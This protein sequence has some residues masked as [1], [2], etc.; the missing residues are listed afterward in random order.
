M[1]GGSLR[2]WQNVVALAKRTALSV[3]GLDGHVAARPPDLPLHLWTT[4][5]SE[6]LRDPRPYDG[7]EGVLEREWWRNDDGYPTD[8][9]W[10]PF[11]A[12]ALK[13]LVGGKAFDFAVIE[14]VVYWRYA[15]VV[16]RY[17]RIVI[18]YHNVQS[19][20][21]EQVLAFLPRRRVVERGRVALGMRTMR[22]VEQAYRGLPAIVCSES[23]KTELVARG[24]ASDAIGVVHNT[25]ALGDER[26]PNVPSKVRTRR[27]LFAGMM[28]YLPNACA[29][30]I[31]VRQ[32]FP[33]VRK[34]IPDA[35]LWIVGINPLPE[36]L[37]AVAGK[38]G[39][40]V[41]GAVAHTEAYFLNSD[42]LSVPL[43]LGGG[44]RFK[45]VEAFKYG[46][47]VVS[48]SKGAEGL[49]VTDGRNVL[50]ADTPARHA[51]RIVAVLR[52]DGLAARL[53]AEG[54]RLCREKYSFA[55]AARQWDDC[56]ARF[57]LIGSD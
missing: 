4:L 2:D 53:A 22:A 41:I 46:L 10:S 5:D 26:E 19:R 1:A 21:D 34:S 45:I 23:E 32:I 31:L 13:Q 17:C 7:K 9:E 25:V 55:T 39:I 8:F 52:D 6:V 28:D 44:T 24:F 40:H 11:R 57:G 48:S 15:E 56:L 20:L 30:L 54:R 33:R 37:R 38:P 51:Q 27:I 42:V 49:E 14:D 29:A 43:S 36:L 47:P 16:R 3:V 18:D 12:A 35:E 50:I